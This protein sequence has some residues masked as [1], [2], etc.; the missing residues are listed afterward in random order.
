L[1]QVGAIFL[2]CVAGRA[3]VTVSHRISMDSLSSGQEVM[4]ELDQE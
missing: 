1:Q 2:W 4:E 3:P